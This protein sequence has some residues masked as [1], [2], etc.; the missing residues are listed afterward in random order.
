MPI[1]VVS[2]GEQ[3]PQGGLPPCPGRIGPAIAGVILR[4]TT[5]VKQ[6]PTG[7]Q[8]PSRSDRNHLQPFAKCTGEWWNGQAE[9]RPAQVFAAGFSHIRGTE[10]AHTP[11][12]LGRSPAAVRR[13]WDREVSII[14]PPEVVAD[15]IR[16]QFPRRRNVARSDAP[17]LQVGSLVNFKHS[18]SKRV[19]KERCE[20]RSRR[21][22]PVTPP[23]T[24]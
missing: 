14:A 24:D 6:G 12:A 22:F 23:K 4:N 21:S 9:T 16:T 1:V 13:S 11:S 2:S 8:Q 7:R 5:W 3:P 20:S 17:A 15:R 10:L 19:R 18:G